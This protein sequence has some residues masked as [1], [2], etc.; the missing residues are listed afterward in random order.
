MWAG[1]T[2]RYWHARAQL[3][4]VRRRLDQQ[5]RLC[6]ETGFR[7][8]SDVGRAV[9]SQWGQR[10]HRAGPAQW[11]AQRH[12]CSPRHIVCAGCVHLDKHALQRV[13]VVLVP[14]RTW[15]ARNACLA[16]CTP[17]VLS[18]ADRTRSTAH[19]HGWPPIQ[20]TEVDAVG[21]IVWSPLFLEQTVVPPAVGL[22]GAIALVDYAA[23][24]SAPFAVVAAVRKK[25]LDVEKTHGRSSVW[26]CCAQLACA[27]LPRTLS[28]VCRTCC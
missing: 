22:T 20:A 15:N 26:P 14:E 9:S 1:L 2:G 10:Q 16:A 24:D 25:A 19:A 7:H 23:P 11:R 4:S 6:S 28:F 21:T 3:C 13:R 5:L 12:V 17:Y 18:R 27:P 8:Q